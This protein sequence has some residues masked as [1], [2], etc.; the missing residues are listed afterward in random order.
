MVVFVLVGVA[1]A[2]AYLIW[3]ATLKLNPGNATYFVE[4]GASL[5]GFSRQLYKQGLLPDPYS[6][7]AL[8][9]LRGRAHDLKTGEYRFRNGITPPQLLQQVVAGRVVEYPLLI[10]EG[11]SFRQMLAALDAAPKLTHTLTGLKPQ[12]IMRRLGYPDLH[13]EGRFFPDTYYYSRGTTDLAIL[14]IAFRKMENLLASE[15]A[16]RDPAVPLKT[17]DEALVLAS[18]VEKETGHVDERRLIAGVFINRLHRRMKLQTDPTVIYG[19][20]ARYRG[21]IRATDLRQDTPYNTYTRYGLPP[22]PIALPGADAVRA[23]L[24]PAHTNALYF[25]SRGDGTHVFSDDLTAHNQAVVRFQL[26]GRRKPAAAP[27]SSLPRV[28]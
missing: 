17:P 7:V 28:R 10:V 25:V 22:T 1:A 4:P 6:L 9:Y 3:V 16:G 15:W 19:M 20:G 11:W 2:G 12:E 26:G 24:H 14:Q 18:I 23:V 8:A 21:N 13:P 5:R 27:N